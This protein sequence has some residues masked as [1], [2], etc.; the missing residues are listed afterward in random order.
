VFVLVRSLFCITPSN[1]AA[2]C[3]PTVVVSVMAAVDQVV[4]AVNSGLDSEVNEEES[5]KKAGEVI[6]IAIPEVSI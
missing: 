6:A 5:R 3:A 2:Y 4:K 1:S